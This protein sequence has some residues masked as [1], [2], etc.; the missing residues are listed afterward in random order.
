MDDDW[1]RK[2]HIQ[3]SEIKFLKHMIIVYMIGSIITIQW[4]NWIY[5]PSMTRQK[6]GC[7][8]GW[9]MPPE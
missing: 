4:L 3:M 6:K 1:E 9:S 7:S 8:N 5:S 2:Q